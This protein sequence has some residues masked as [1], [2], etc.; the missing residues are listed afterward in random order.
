MEAHSPSQSTAGISQ[1]E[2]RDVVARST[3]RG[4]LHAC[5]KAAVARVEPPSGKAIVDY[6]VESDGSVSATA[7]R[8]GSSL[9]DA[10]F[11][12]CLLQAFRG[13][14]FSARP[15]GEAIHLTSRLMYEVH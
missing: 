4:A 13:F 5:H 6:V 2:V 9:S 8:D 3:I 14:V 1:D 12:S 15:P 10:R 7:L 11:E